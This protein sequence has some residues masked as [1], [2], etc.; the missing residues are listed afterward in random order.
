[1]IL[2]AVSVAVKLAGVATTAGVT[3]GFEVALEAGAGAD[4]EDVDG[5]TVDGADVEETGPAVTG[6]A[7]LSASIGGD[8]VEG[9]ADIFDLN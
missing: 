7:G 1:M 2:V 4:G 5:A 8:V 3:A 6:A 9:G